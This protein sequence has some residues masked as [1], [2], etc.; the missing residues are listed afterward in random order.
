MLPAL[1]PDLD[2]LDPSLYLRTVLARIAD[3]PINRISELL[4]WNL[5]ATLQSKPAEAA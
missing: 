1:Q 2:G 5:L 3:Y 4:L